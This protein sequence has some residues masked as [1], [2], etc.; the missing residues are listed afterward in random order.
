MIDLIDIIAS[1][2][3]SFEDEFFLETHR[4]NYVWSDPEYPGGNNEIRPFDGNYDKW[5]EQSGIPYGRCKGTHVIR[6][7]CGPNVKIITKENEVL[8]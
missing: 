5:C 2:T 4:G 1:F 8:A 3:W 6:D 7:Y